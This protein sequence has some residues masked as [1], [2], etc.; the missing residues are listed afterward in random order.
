M[1]DP[2]FFTGRQKGICVFGL[3]R[4]GGVESRTELNSRTA[5]V[6]VKFGRR[7]VEAGLVKLLS[8]SQSKNTL[9]IFRLPVKSG[10]HAVVGGA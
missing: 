1:R 6:G 8:E 2:E 5:G 10:K 4:A 7:A 3:A 9:S